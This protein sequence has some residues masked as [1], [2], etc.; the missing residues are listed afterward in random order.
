MMNELI[1]I[2]TDFNTG[3]RQRLAGQKSIPYYEK[4]NSA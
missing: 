1:T 3:G 2:H 4:E